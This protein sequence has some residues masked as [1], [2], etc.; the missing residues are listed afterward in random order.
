[1]EK[2]SEN[3]RSKFDQMISIKHKYYLQRKYIP[4]DF[5]E[6][7]ISNQMRRINNS[8][9]SLKHLLQRENGNS[10]RLQERES[11]YSSQRRNNFPEFSGKL[12]LCKSSCKCGHFQLTVW[13]IQSELK[14]GVFNI[15]RNNR[16]LYFS[17]GTYF[18]R[19]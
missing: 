18:I 14:Y 3:E 16:M 19:D 9:K 11:V 2:Y 13:W 17:C 15:K 5:Y 4:Q 7:P 1:M 12:K 6:H 10:S 8:G